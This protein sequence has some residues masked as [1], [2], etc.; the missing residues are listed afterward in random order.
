MDTAKRVLD[1]TEIVFYVMAA[2]GI[3]FLLSFIMP[4]ISLLNWVIGR[5]VSPVRAAMSAFSS[6][7]EPLLPTTTRG[8]PTIIKIKR[9]AE[10]GKHKLRLL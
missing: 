8:Q 6:S 5:A 9:V 1:N 7:R 4:F 2:C 10:K 3:L